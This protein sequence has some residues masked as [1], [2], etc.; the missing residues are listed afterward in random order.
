MEIGQLDFRHRSNSPL[1]YCCC[2]SIGVTDGVQDITQ[3]YLV[4]VFFKTLMSFLSQR[5]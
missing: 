1:N 5:K 4:S 2:K 3:S